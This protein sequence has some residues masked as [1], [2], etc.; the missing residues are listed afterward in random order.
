MGSSRRSV[1][2][3][4]LVGCVGSSALVMARVLGIMPDG[5][6]PGG[7]RAGLAIPAGAG[8]DARRGAGAGG[9]DT[10]RAAIRFAG[11]RLGEVSRRS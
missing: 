10:G 7:P 6:G 11:R 2:W 4:G 8:R 1:D 9:G 3:S 5:A